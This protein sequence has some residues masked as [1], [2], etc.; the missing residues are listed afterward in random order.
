[1]NFYL[2]LHDEKH[3][4]FVCMCMPNI[5]ALKFGELDILAV[6]FTDNLWRPRLIEKSKFLGEID[7]LCHQVSSKDLQFYKVHFENRNVVYDVVPLDIELPCAKRVGVIGIDIA[8]DD[9]VEQN[10]SALQYEWH[11]VCPTR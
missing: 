1:M 8:V 9:N 6:E 10:L 2:T 3:F 7:C 11:N 4:I 5:L